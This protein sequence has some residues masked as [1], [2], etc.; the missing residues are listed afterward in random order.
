MPSEPGLIEFLVP[1]ERA[2]GPAEGDSLG[3]SG[4]GT[5]FVGFDGDLWDDQPARSPRSRWLPILTGIAVTGLVV[6][7]V[8]AAAPW[9]ADDAAATPTT[10]AEQTASNPTTLAA[11]PDAPVDPSL[12]GWVLDPVPTGVRPTYLARSVDLRPDESGWGEVWASPGATRASGRW[13]SLTLQPFVEFSPTRPEL[14]FAVDVAGRPGHARVATDSV[15]SLSYDAGQPDSSR[16]VTI[17]AYGMGLEEMT[18]LAD[19]IA[20]VDDRPQMVDDRPV[21]TRPELLNGLV[22]IVAARTD[23]DLTTSAIL[24]GTQ[25]TRALYSGPGQFDVT[26][27]Q[28]QTLH[29]AAAGGDVAAL[30]A[31]AF[32]SVPLADGWGPKGDFAGNNLV[33]GYRTIDDFDLTVA[34][35]R[36]GETELSLLTT[37]DLG[38][39]L[40]MLPHVKLAS[41][42]DWA[43][44]ERS[45]HTDPHA[46]EPSPRTPPEIT[47]DATVEITLAF[48]VD[49]TA[50]DGTV[51]HRFAP[52]DLEPVSRP[53][54][55]SRGDG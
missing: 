50:A 4:A 3:G 8:V 23:M 43:A 36:D 1:D 9:S 48:T 10:V 30:I 42:E 26:L 51:V 12:T 54:A 52:W 20:I 47:V 40:E 44:A 21:F 17:D 32:T 16:L 25:R 7:G 41:A 46:D 19:S 29:V 35:W 18:A 37:G 39:L 38:D 55:G 13:F 22:Q 28:E 15:V 33:V 2:F 6:S 34:R 49:V 27:V 31:L 45:L 24:G 5:T 53:A 14:W 11:I